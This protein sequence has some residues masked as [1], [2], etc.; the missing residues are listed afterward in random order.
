VII[1]AT[2]QRDRKRTSV[3]AL[4]EF[5]SC[6]LLIER[7]S[8]D[9]DARWLLPLSATARKGPEVCAGLAHLADLT[10]FLTVS[11]QP[12]YSQSLEDPDDSV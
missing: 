12:T 10:S 1:V 2:R 9:C 7:V 11:S 6:V 5:P 4:G 8:C 3:G